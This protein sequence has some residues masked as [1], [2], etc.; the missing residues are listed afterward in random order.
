MRR[1]AIRA[2][3]RSP[4]EAASPEGSRGRQ[5]LTLSFAVPRS[6]GAVFAT[7]RSDVSAPY[8]RR[9]GSA[10]GRVLCILAIGRIR[11]RGQRAPRVAR[12]RRTGPYR[13]GRRHRYVVRPAVRRRRVGRQY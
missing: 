9:Q 8:I 5:I 2:G 10:R 11:Y 3:H 13:S 1:R 12:R 7:R 4:D 6:R